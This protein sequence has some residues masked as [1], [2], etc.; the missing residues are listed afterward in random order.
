[1]MLGMAGCRLAA[2]SGVHEGTAAIML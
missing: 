1:L 2:K